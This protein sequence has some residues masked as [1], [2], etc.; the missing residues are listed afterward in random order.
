MRCPRFALVEK[1][2]TRNE[3]PV[4]Q[5]LPLPRLTTERIVPRTLA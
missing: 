5:D 2:E 1:L 4:R 3:K